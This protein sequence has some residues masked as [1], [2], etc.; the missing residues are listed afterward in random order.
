VLQKLVVAHPAVTDPVKVVLKYTAYKGWIYSGISR[1]SLD[2]LIITNSFG[3]SYSFCARGLLLPSGIS[4]TVSLTKGVCSMSNFPFRYPHVHQFPPPPSSSH[5]HTNNM[6]HPHIFRNEI[7]ETSSSSDMTVSAGGSSSSDTKST[8]LP[9]REYMDW[10]NDW[11]PIIVNTTASPITETVGVRCDNA[12]EDCMSYSGKANATESTLSSSTP[13]KQTSEGDQLNNEIDDGGSLGERRSSRQ[14]SP[15]HLVP[16][17]RAIEP[18]PVV[19]LAP[20]GPVVQR[21]L[22]DD[23]GLRRRPLLSHILGTDELSP[24]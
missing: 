20:R 10:S 22:E 4:V 11:H 12:E 1:W 16:L 17:S 8:R 2:R 3:L 19:F 18:R 9:E 14:L 23:P 7:N 24:M 5:G 13:S 21:S 6:I 15:V